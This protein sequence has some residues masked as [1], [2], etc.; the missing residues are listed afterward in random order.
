[1]VKV[2]AVVDE[3]F[4]DLELMYPVLRMQAAGIEVVFAGAEK[5]Y[6]YTGKYG[7]PC[8]VSHQVQ[9]MRH[10]EFQ[11]VLIPGG[12]APDRL[13]RHTAVLDFVHNMDRSKK[14]IAFICHGGWVPISAKILKGRTATGTR[15]IK[16]DLENAGACWE[17]SPVVIDEHLISSRTP[18]DLPQFGEAIV[19]MLID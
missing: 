16:D 1:M 11:G 4:E 12:F 17:D 5:G 6:I 14:M 8:Q 9:D 10:E 2:L 7:Y 19:K 13:R 15:A 18:L 3:L